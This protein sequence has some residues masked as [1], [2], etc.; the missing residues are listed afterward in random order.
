MGVLKNKE[1]FGLQAGP[2]FLICISL[3]NNFT[4]NSNLSN[5]VRSRNIYPKNVIIQ[6]VIF[7]SSLLFL[8]FNI[9][10]KMEVSENLRQFFMLHNVHRKTVLCGIFRF[11]VYC[12]AGNGIEE[13]ANFHCL[14]FVDILLFG[15]WHFVSVCFN[16]NFGIFRCG[17]QLRNFHCYRK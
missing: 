5:Y 11:V 6:Q 1:T 15:F 13:I 9:L 4:I 7:P 3:W 16:P 2:A 14:L 10:F 8:S 12:F 17:Q